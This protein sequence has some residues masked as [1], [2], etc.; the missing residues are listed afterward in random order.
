MP[1]AP[2]WPDHTDVASSDGVTLA[3]YDLASYDLASTTPADALPAEP[4][5]D[6]LLV[7]ANGFCAAVFAPLAAE[8]APWR[9]VAFDA[10]AHG[11][12]T[13]PTGDMAWEGHRDDVL[14]VV[15][16]FGL[17]APVGIGHS[18]GGAALLLAEQMRP[19]TFSALWLF[20]PIVFPPMPAG[21]GDSGGDNPLAEGA[22]R[23]RDSFD[24][25][26]AAYANFRSKP[27]LS[28]LSEACLAAYVTHGFVPTGEGESVTLR[29]RPENEAAGYRMGIR[30]SA[31]EHLGDVGCPVVVARGSD[32]VP[33][34]AAVAPA[35]AQR[36][37]QGCL[38]EHPELGHFGPLSDPAS[39]A[40]SIR[41]LANQS[42]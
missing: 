26:G 16:A 42:G 29:C 33:G 20:E 39:A 1:P 31:W 34:P 38:E 32:R 35:I 8:L 3:A 23:R 22:M 30:H 15:D 18:M 36:L 5:R 11:T 19:G 28:E 27:P 17:D 7:H 37:G 24:S 25:T 9:C 13:P 40:A 10:R 4:D 41:A 12:S 21:T 2:L 14:A 6:A